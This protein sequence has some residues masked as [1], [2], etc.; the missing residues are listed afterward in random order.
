MEFKAPINRIIDTKF[1]SNVHSKQTRI[2]QPFNPFG[3]S[4]PIEYSLCISS[5][6]SSFR[7]FLRRFLLK[8]LFAS[9]AIGRLLFFFGFFYK[10][11]QISFYLALLHALLLPFPFELFGIVSILFLFILFNSFSLFPFTHSLRF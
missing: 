6:F 8:K 3:F 1:A 9:Y 5:L 10:F 2:A 7:R 11:F 4:F